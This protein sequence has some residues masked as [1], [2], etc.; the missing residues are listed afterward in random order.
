MGPDRA[1]GVRAHLQSGLPDQPPAGWG[2]S[3]MDHMGGNFMAVAILAGA[4]PPQ[5]HRRGPVG[6]HGVHRGRRHADGPDLL[7]Y[8]VNGRP[9]RRPGQPDSNRSHSPA[10]APHGIYT[11]RGDD[12][13]VAIACRDDD[14]WA[15]A[16][17]R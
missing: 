7:D 16:R 5:P 14:D 3:Y 12:E 9:L 4:D 17:A 10:M 15:R 2:Y 1:G 13:W 11:A 8:T 6:R